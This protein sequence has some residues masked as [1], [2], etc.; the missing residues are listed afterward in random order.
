MTRQSG[1]KKNIILIQGSLQ[2]NTANIDSQTANPFLYNTF[3]LPNNANISRCY[4]EVANQNEYPDIHFKPATNPARV[5]RELMGYIYG[6][7]DFQGGTLLSISNFES[8]F[9]FVYFDLTKQKMDIKDGVT[10]LSFHYELSAN[11]NADYNFCAILNEREAEIKQ[12][13]GKLLL[14]A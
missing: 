1:F 13:D 7:N 6:N 5:F 10:K 9:P 2:V 11:P 8:L 4:L 3:N 12:E 14:R